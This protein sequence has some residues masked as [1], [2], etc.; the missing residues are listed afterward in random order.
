[1]SERESFQRLRRAYRSAFGSEEGRIVLGDL[2]R[3][4]FATRSVYV[5]GDPMATTLNEGQR[6]VWLRIQRVLTLTDDQIYR[7]QEEAE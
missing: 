7:L 3:F 6:R 2:S 5:P 4:C 1:V